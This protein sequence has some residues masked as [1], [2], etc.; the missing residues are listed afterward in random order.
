MNKFRVALLHYAEIK[1]SNSMLE[2][3]WLVL[4]NSSALFHNSIAT[5]LYFFIISTL[6]IYIS[7]QSAFVVKFISC[8]FVQSPWI[9][10]VHT[11]TIFIFDGNNLSKR[12]IAINSWL[13]NTWKY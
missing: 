10:Q 1:N 6:Q 13:V 5:L 11:Y 2:V 4:A 3:I 8:M 7:N 12:F 9:L